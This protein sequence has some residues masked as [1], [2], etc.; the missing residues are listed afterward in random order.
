MSADGYGEKLL[1]IDLASRTASEEAVPSEILRQYIGGAGLGVKYVFDEVPSETDPLGPGNKLVIACGPFTGTS[2][3]C[4]SRM[5][6]VARSPLTGGMALGLSGGYFPAELK[7]CGYIAIIV[8]GK[9]DRPVY[10]AISRE[11]VRFVNGAHVWGTRTSDCQ[12][13]IKDQLRNQNYRVACIGPAGEKLSRLACI[14]NERRAAGRKGFGAIMGA[15]NLKAIAVLGTGSVGIVDDQSYRHG[16]NEMRGWMKES[17]VLYPFFS[18]YGTSRGIDNHS[19]QGIFPARNWTAT[20]EFVPVETLGVEARHTQTIGRAFCATCPVGCGQL[21]LA[22]TGRYAAILAE[23][24]E[25]ETVYAYGGQTGVADLDS[26]IAADRLSDELGI[27]TISAG[28][29]IGFAMELFERGL[30]SS[31][32][33]DGLD[34]S[35]G[36]HESMLEL[37]QKMA[38]RE[39]FG[40]VLA[41][42]VRIAAA[43]LGKDTEY[44]AMHVKGLELPAYDPR[45]A[46]AQGLNLATAFTGADH[47]RGYAIQEIFGTPVPFAV[48]RFS[49]ERKGELTKWNQDVRTATCDCPTMCAF[50]FDTALAPHALDNTSALMKAVTGMDLTPEEVQRVG[51]RINNLAR[52]FN[53]REGFTRADDTLPLR[54][55]TE[56]LTCGASQGHVVGVDDF[57]AML[58][59][60]YLARGWDVATGV[61]GREKLVELGLEGAIE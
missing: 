1:R 10:V 37:L 3:P 40:D 59:E 60:Y 13:I 52:V 28:V 22:K 47:N 15:K 42:G 18:K 11:T 57:R 61:P 23:G 16:L 29:T 50:V 39:G 32:D 26:I 20:G 51:E 4:S 54:V 48:D 38:L 44:Y 14:V 8:E 25:Y 30:L 46:K 55:L 43:R 53:V 34:L 17:P 27:D 6:V 36:N 45:G 7:R 19:A 24:P 5:A 33:A 56:P 35:F 9:A 58:D 21:M 31:E 12:Q 41:D 2:I 49:A